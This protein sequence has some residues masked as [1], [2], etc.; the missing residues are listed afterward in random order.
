ML[1]EWVEMGFASEFIPYDCMGACVYIYIFT[2]IYDH[3]CIIL[4]YT[5]IYIY[6]YVCIYI[7]IIIYTVYIYI[8][9]NYKITQKQGCWLILPV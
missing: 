9:I 6:V 1:P 7:I 3:T 2:C 8:Y 5:C 4:I